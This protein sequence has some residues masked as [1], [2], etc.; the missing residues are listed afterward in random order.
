LSRA[1]T[2]IDIALRSDPAG[3]TRRS[4]SASKGD[5]HAMEHYLIVLLIGFILGLIIGVSLA[6]PDFIGR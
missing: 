4:A 1:D 6:K 5:A 2:P 3:T